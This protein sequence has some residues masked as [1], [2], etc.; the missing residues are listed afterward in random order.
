MELKI[1][2]TRFMCTSINLHKCISVYGD[3]LWQY[4]ELLPL[5]L[6]ETSVLSSLAQMDT[7]TCV[8]FEI[9]I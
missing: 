5:F 4:R 9:L 1:L 2:V 3:L 6:S 8:L 7:L